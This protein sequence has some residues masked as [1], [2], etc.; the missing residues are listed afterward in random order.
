[1]HIAIIGASGFLGKNLTKYLLENT[2]LEITAISLEPESISI[3]DKYQN[4]FKNIK[5]DVL[6][7]EEISRALSGIDIAYYFIHMMT[8]YKNN[9][10]D[11]EEAA[12]ETTGKALKSNGVKRVIYMSGLG[13]D[14]KDLSK[15]LASRHNTGDILRKYIHEVIEFRASMIIGEGSAS[16]EIARNIIDK[17]PI[18]TL[19]R[20]SKTKT[21][22]IGITDALLYLKEAVEIKI[23]KP[24]IVEIGGGDVMS[25]VEFVK[26][27]RDYRHKKNIIIRI[28]F[29]SERVAG[30]SLPLLMNKN[31]ARVGQNMLSSFRNEMIVT[32]NR[33]RELFPNINP[34]KI[35]EFFI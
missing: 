11:K 12:A 32:N 3:E 28:P 23:S 25:Y 24:E 34:H 35:E 27:Y 16:F 13:N 22:P 7:D 2:D 18:I 33:A 9:F 19:P 14:S 17:A 30:K 20:W 15:H 8:N 21:Q 5:A 1:M 31:Y 26:K 29:L 6:R 10:Y 4:R